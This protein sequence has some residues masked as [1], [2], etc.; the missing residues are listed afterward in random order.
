MLMALGLQMHMAARSIRCYQS[1]PGETLPENGIIA[2]C[3]QT[4]GFIK[5]YL[6]KPLYKAHTSSAPRPMLAIT[7]KPTSFPD[8]PSPA[9]PVPATPSADYICSTEFLPPDPNE[10]RRHPPTP[11]STP[12]PLYQPDI[13]LMPDESPPER[14]I[15]NPNYPSDYHVQWQ[16]ME[17]AEGPLFQP[18]YQHRQ[19]A[20]SIRSFVDDDIR[21][22]HREK[23]GLERL[24]AIA[25][26]LGIELKNSHLIIS[27]KTTIA[28]TKI[29]YARIIKKEL[30]KVGIKAKIQ[31]SAMDLGLL[32]SAGQRRT[33]SGMAKRI[34]EG[35]NRAKRTSM[36]TKQSRR[37]RKTYLAGTWAAS[38]YGV[39]GYGLG[40][41]AV[42]QLRANAPT[43]I[44]AAA[45]G[46]CAIT[47]VAV[48]VGLHCHPLVPTTQQMIKLWCKIR[49]NMTQHDLTRLKVAW[50]K[51]KA[52]VFLTTPT[53]TIQWARVRG[54]IGALPK[55]QEQIGWLTHGPDT[56][57]SPP[58]P[59]EEYSTEWNIQE[60]MTCP[61]ALLPRR[62]DH[63]IKYLWEEVAQHRYGTDL[64]EGGDFTSASKHYSWLIKKADAR[65]P[66]C[67][68]PYYREH[69]GQ[70]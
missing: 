62:K 45:R 12:S 4:T 31:T 1:Y 8:T 30:A 3:A 6:H 68:S 41:R 58:D 22:S 48:T 20:N 66:P 55:H 7:D 49:F 33:F 23:Y 60:C 21:C 57:Y 70:R 40:P 29:E 9:T 54:P 47:A 52:H 24:T 50:D 56:W 44:G 36:L 27:A 14:E 61:Q 18:A 42:T 43:A 11:P 59:G 34:R 35:K 38:T 28:S 46:G 5:V 51:A 65:K 13:I 19:C 37:T 10:Q 39:E 64:A 16:Q 67:S 53:S 63:S 2:G 32:T 15:P 69:Y 25:K 17:Q 26:D